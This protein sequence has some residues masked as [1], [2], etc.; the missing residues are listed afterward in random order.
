MFLIFVVPDTDSYI[1]SR[2]EIVAAI[3]LLQSDRVGGIRRARASINNRLNYSDCWLSLFPNKSPISCSQIVH[4]DSRA[5][6]Y[7]GLV[8][9]REAR[10]IGS[11]TIGMR[12]P[13]P[14]G[15]SCP[16]R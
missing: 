7:Q 8:D 4:S 3:E 13:R 12:P 10:L 2:F 5:D 14:Q 9:R 15:D 6:S 1:Q 16:G 11:V